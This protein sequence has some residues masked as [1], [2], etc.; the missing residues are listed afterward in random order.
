MGLKDVFNSLM[1]GKN[2]V[3]NFMAKYRPPSKEL[4]RFAI[5]YRD[6]SELWKNCKRSDWLLWM[7]ASIDYKPACALRLFSCYCARQFWNLVGDERSRAVVEVAEKFARQ[8]ASVD[9]LNA[10]RTKAYEALAEAKRKNDNLIEAI[11]W[12]AAATAKEDAFT[13]A[14]DCASYA[15]TIAE[16]KGGKHDVERIREQQAYKLRALLGNPFDTSDEEVARA[17]KNRY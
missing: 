5:R 1:A 14:Y 13:S 2:P 16:I 17:R 8:E 12:A 9:Q 7:I 10:A 3:T 15:A 6:L 4:Y 11:A